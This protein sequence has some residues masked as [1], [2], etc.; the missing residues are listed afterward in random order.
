MTISDA[1]VVFKNYPKILSK[2]KVLID[3]G[4]GYI[5][6]GQQSTTLSGGEAQRIK[7]ATELLKK[8]LKDFHIFD[9]PTTG[10]HF[11]DIDQLMKI[12]IKLSEKGNTIIIIEHNTDVLKIVDHLLSWVLVEEKMVVR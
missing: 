12:I 4:L 1:A 3:V 6:L 9:E 11:A 8:I 7:L 5:R 10:L 2:L